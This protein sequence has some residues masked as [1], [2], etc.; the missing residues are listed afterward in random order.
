MAKR[1]RTP[2]AK[3]GELVA[4]WGTVEGSTDICYAWGDGINKSDSHLLHSV[5]STPRTRLN[6]DAEFPA[7]RFNATVDEPSLLA[8]LEARGYDLTTLRFS[9]RKKSDYGSAK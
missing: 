6:W 7:S 2:K 4:R 9:V 1:W 8:E 5:L 3:P